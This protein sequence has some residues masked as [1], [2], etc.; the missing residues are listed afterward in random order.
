M[1]IR[2]RHEYAA[3]Q[4]E[5]LN[6][7]AC[8]GVVESLPTLSLMGEKL[9]PEWLASIL[10]GTLFYKPRPWLESR[11]PAFAS[12]GKRIAQGLAML[13]GYPPTSS[14][15][16]EP[17]ED[18]VAVGQKLISANG[19]LACVTCHAVGDMPATAVFESN[20]INFAYA[21]ERLQPDFFHRW[22][23][24][25]TQIDPETKMPVYFFGGESPLPDILEGNATDQ[26]KAIWEYF[27]QGFDI[28]AP[29]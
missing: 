21:N 16:S 13:N 22:I 6:C 12:R 10:E 25:P 5:T 27:K 4:V 2:D 18:L 7:A 11:M 19:G 24:K 28:E 26:I 8:H 9:K 29:E 1:C 3:S 14:R 15:G 23:L 20:G 17:E